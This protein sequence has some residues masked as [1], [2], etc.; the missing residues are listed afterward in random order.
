MAL[1]RKFTG[2]TTSTGSIRFLGEGPKKKAKLTFDDDAIF[3]GRNL[4]GIF[5]EF[6]INPFQAGST[7]EES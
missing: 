2:K 5:W 3:G 4:A 6:S 7:I 1:I